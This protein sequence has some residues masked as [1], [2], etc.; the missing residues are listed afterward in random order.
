MY[1]CIMYIDLKMYYFLRGTDQKFVEDTGI[2]IVASL[3]KIDQEHI[4][5]L[6]QLLLKAKNYYWIKSLA[7]QTLLCFKSL[8]PL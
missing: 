5:M 3:G 1:V 6:C 2:Y 8:W 4:I 7:S